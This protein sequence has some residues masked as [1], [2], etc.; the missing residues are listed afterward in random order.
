MCS[1][2]LVQNSP[3]IDGIVHC[4]GINKNIPFSF[5]SPANL[6]EVMNINFFAPIEL[7]RLLLKAKKIINAGS[8]VFIN[9]VS[10]IYC[11][12]PASSMYSASKG[13]LNGMMKGMAL[14]L[15]SKGI[16]VNGIAPGVI[17]TEIFSSGIITTEQLEENKKTYPLKRFGEPIEVAHAAIYLLSDAS[18][19]IT[20][21]NLLIDGGL[22][23][24]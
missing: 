6:N 13:A 19:W 22:T 20:G 23:L 9:S 14:D 12:A 17:N 15:A 3:K 1:S 5:A 7:T 18:K 4:A 24:L 16:R 21:S 8:I 11:S 2:D 10:G